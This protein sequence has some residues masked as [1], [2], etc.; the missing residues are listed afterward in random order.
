MTVPGAIND[1]LDSISIIGTPVPD[2]TGQTGVW[3]FFLHIRVVAD[4]INTGILRHRLWISGITVL[5][6]DITPHRKECFGSR[7]LGI[8]VIPAVGNFD[9][10]GCIR[11]DG[12][13]TDGKGI[14]TA[15]HLR[16]RGILRSNIADLIGR[17]IHT[18]DNTAQVTSLIDPTEIVGK[19]FAIALI[20]GSVTEI[21]IWIF[22]CHF[23]CHIHISPTGGKDDVTALI[24]AFLNGG[25]CCICIRVIDIDLSD[26]L[27]RGKPKICL[28]TLNT[29]VVRVGVTAS[30]CRVGQMENS[31]FDL[32]F[33][34]ARG[35]HSI[36]PAGRRNF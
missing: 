32:V 29:K 8:R 23:F 18:G 11:I 34:D 17:S 14:N 22:R 19:I 12:G 27:V 20:A 21:D 13:N 16:I 5:R 2:Y 4:P 1:T 9:I 24:N 28:H 10:D 15:G 7:P 31:N 36:R 25:A 6:H 3:S 33:R 35:C 26:D 30:L